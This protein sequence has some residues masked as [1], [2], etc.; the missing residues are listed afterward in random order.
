MIRFVPL[1]AIVPEPAGKAVKATPL[2]VVVPEPLNFQARNHVP[3]VMTS[4]TAPVMFCAVLH[5]IGAAP[6]DE[7]TCV[8]T[9]AAIATAPSFKVCWREAMGSLV[10]F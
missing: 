4:L 7:R 8:R 2:T 3:V 5:V 10:V 1:V 6:A 9:A